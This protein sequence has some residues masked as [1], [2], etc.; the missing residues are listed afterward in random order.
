ML[1]WSSGPTSSPHKKRPNTNHH[2]FLFW[3]SSDELNH[4]ILRRTF[5][6]LYKAPGYELAWWLPCRVARQ[7]PV[8]SYHQVFHCLALRPSWPLSPVNETAL[9]FFRLSSYSTSNFFVYI[10]CGLIFIDCLYLY[11][12]LWV[13]F[14]KT[15]KVHKSSFKLHLPVA[16]REILEVAPM[17]LL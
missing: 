3:V 12:P 16:S 6:V 2:T 4:R 8:T 14:Q 10:E 5:L 1:N 13:L 9:L 17:H 7:T 15:S 11:L